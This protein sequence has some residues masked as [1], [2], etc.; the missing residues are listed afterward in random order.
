MPLRMS[1]NKGATY[2][3]LFLMPSTVGFPVVRK[4]QHLHRRRTGLVERSGRPMTRRRRIT[5]VDLVQSYSVPL[6]RTLYGLRTNPH[7]QDG[8]ENG[9]PS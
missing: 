6:L 7:V 9:K 3:C 2:G 1:D 5:V 4:D 8:A